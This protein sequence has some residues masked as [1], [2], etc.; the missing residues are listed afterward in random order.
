MVDLPQDKKEVSVDVELP[1][2]EILSGAVLDQGTGHG[3]AGVTVA[4]DGGFDANTTTVD[5]PLPGITKTDQQGHFQLV[6]PP[7]RGI[8]ATLSPAPSTG[9]LERCMTRTMIFPGKSTCW[10]ASRRAK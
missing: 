5:G 3:V 9:G 2:G 6:V 4:F 8:A 1:R 10:P 7:G